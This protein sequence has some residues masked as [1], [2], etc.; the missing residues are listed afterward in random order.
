MKDMSLRVMMR[1]NLQVKMAE[2]NDDEIS[3]CIEIPSQVGANKF[4]TFSFFH[5]VQWLDQRIQFNNIREDEFKNDVSAHKQEV[6]CL[7]QKY[8]AS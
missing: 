1:L 8:K 2:V 3:L 6:I 7:I 4:C 5:H